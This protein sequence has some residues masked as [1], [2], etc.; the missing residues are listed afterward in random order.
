MLA[1]LGRVPVQQQVCQERLL[2]RGIQVQEGLPIIDQ[3]KVAQQLDL[4]PF[5]QGLRSLIQTRIVSLVS[6]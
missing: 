3:M 5:F 4:Q 6:V 1:G 2:A